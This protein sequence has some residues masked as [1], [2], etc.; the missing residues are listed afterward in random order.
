LQLLR[1]RLLKTRTVLE[2]NLRITVSL[3]SFFSK[4]TLLEG[5]SSLQSESASIYQ[6]LIWELE[7]L[8]HRYKS[9]QS[10]VMR[11]LEVADGTMS[12]LMKILDYRHDENIRTNISSTRDLL[13][14][15]EQETTVLRL[16]ASQTQQ[17]SRSMKIVTFVALIYLPGTLVASV[18]SS[19]IIK[20][21]GTG[22]FGFNPSEQL[23]SFL[24]VTALLTVVTVSG[25]VLW[26]KGLW[27]RWFGKIKS[28]PSP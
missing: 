7:N 5:S 21:D 8:L 6:D 9:H 25:A 26:D 22:R 23:L 3:R 20:E 18:Y 1:Q 16:I 10:S 24:V 11:L 17:D 15:A 14:A 13:S 12:L 4:L 2:T 19:H 28:G 27:T